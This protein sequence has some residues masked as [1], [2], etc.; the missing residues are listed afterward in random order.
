MPV[1]RRP[2]IRPP[3]TARPQK[4]RRGHGVK[5]PASTILPMCARYNLRVSP[6]KLAEIFNVVRGVEYQPRFNIAPTQDI[7]AI[8]QQDGARVA[9]TMRW[10]LVPSWSK[11][12]KAG[13]PLIIARGETVATT[14]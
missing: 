14:N 4:L 2:D 6:R 5:H 3:R 8:R 7:V 1:G 13:A 9:S 12:P 10:G 11:D